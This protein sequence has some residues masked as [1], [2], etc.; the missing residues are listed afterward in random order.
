MQ[1]NLELFE[2]FEQP[3]SFGEIVL[4]S[5]CNECG[6]AFHKPVLATVASG[7]QVQT[8]Y[9]CPRCMVQVSKEREEESPVEKVYA[10][11]S[12]PSAPASEGDSDCMKFL[13]YLKSRPKSTPVPDEC[14]TCSKMIECLL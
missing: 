7:G 1:K 6:G 13:G 3:D 11:S 14:L 12:P 10:S 9:A 8:Y 2:R 4:D 5:V